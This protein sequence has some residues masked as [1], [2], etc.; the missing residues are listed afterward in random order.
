VRER[1]KKEKNHFGEVLLTCQLHHNRA[2][3]CIDRWNQTENAFLTQWSTMW[4][5]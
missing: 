2:S 3:V 1:E 4:S 5:R